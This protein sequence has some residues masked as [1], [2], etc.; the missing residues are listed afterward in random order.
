MNIGETEIM[1]ILLFTIFFLIIFFLFF[2]HNEEMKF[3]NTPINKEYCYGIEDKNFK[4]FI[5]V[6]ND[7]EEDS[8][9]S[10]IEKKLSKWSSCKK[11]S[12]VYKPSFINS[13]LVAI[14]LEYQLKDK[15]FRFTID[16][17]TK[18]CKLKNRGDR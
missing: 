7:I 5:K 8:S 11:V 18:L 4:K 6:F 12:T 1:K 2:Y 9:M 13:K 15:I 3:E 14:S 16:P 10:L 17:N